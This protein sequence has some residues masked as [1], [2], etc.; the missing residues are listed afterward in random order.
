VD[1]FKKILKESFY[2]VIASSLMGLISGTVLS[3]NE[4]L[5]YAFPVVL[6]ILP[7]LN[8]LIGDFST[9]LISR[10]T[11]NFYIGTIPAKIQKSKQLKTD[12]YGLILSIVF[13]LI[14]LVF[15]G[16]IVALITK[17][18]IVNPFLIILSIFLTGLILFATLFIFLFIGSVYI[19]QQGKDPNNFLIPMVSSLA[20][21]LSPL[22]LILFIQIFI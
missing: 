14:F 18:Q 11:T 10:L 2:I 16:Y 3:Y 8:S 20:D 7:A 1:Y 6:L 5:L 15:L 9:I 21:F 22:F 4:G 17:V 19:F 13:S 12:F